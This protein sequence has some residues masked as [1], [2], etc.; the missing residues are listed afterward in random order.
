MRPFA[1]GY[2]LLAAPLALLFL[3]LLA[4]HSPDPTF[5]TYSARYARFLVVAGGAVFGVPLLVALGCRRARSVAPAQAALLALVGLVVGSVIVETVL[6]RR[7]SL[8]DPFAEYAAWGHQ[9]SLLFAFEAKPN[10]RWTNAGATYT[11][12]RFG[13]RT[14]L[15]G[16][17]EESHGPRI[18][19]VGES[20][21]FG[22]GLNDDQTWPE[23]LEEKLRMRRQE[24]TLD[25]VNAGNNGHTSLQTLFRFYVRV[26]PHAPTAVVLYLGPNDLFGTGPDRLLISDDIL[27]SGSVAGYWSAATRGQ[28]L[29]AR[30]LLFYVVQQHVP[31][32]ARAMR[33]EP[34]A[35]R[36]EPLPPEEHPGDELRRLL[37]TIGGGY[38]ENVRTLCLIARAHG[39]TPV[40]L[41]FMHD[42]DGRRQLLLDHNNALLR[43]L[44]AE[45]GIAVID[46]AA[47]FAPVPEKAS[48]F[49]ADRYHPNRKGAE[50]IA[51]TAAAQWPLGADDPRVSG[52]GGGRR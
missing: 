17:W 50:F 14:H 12:D 6:T 13:F 39:V 10:N 31:P 28:N 38:L 22:Y 29:Y 8:D 24:P 7:L 3:P 20:S 18:F 1:R 23:L 9:R 4:H 36:S 47:A 26:L 43:T 46:V 32:L 19:T 41:T 2:L 25:V 51:A 30:S 21:V 42:M 40:L 16:S 45:D 33:P 48:Y 5:L 15:H 49:F 37:A 11:T 35:E 34:V 52:A 27:F 44:A